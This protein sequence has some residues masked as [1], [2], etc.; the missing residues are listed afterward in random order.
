MA[1]RG[2]PAKEN[3]KETV[4]L[5]INQDQYNWLEA[6]GKAEGLSIGEMIDMVLTMERERHG[7]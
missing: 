6:K 7:N 5:Y 1:E 4:C 2:R 3:K